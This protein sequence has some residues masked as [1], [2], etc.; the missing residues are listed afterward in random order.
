MKNKI[1]I[2]LSL[3]L[4]L[5]VAFSCVASADMDFHPFF[6]WNTPYSHLMRADGKD[7]SET[8][9][10]TQSSNPTQRWHASYTG[11]KDMSQSLILPS[12]EDFLS[13]PAGAKVTIRYRVLSNRD[14]IGLDSSSAEIQFVSREGSG[15]LFSIRQKL[16]FVSSAPTDGSKLYRDFELVIENTSTLTL[17]FNHVRIHCTSSAGYT[18]TLGIENLRYHVWTEAEKA[19][20]SQVD[21]INKQTETIT[22]GW[23]QSEVDPPPGA[24]KMEDYS[25]QE[26]ELLDGQQSGLE[27]GKQS[28]SQT[29]TDIYFYQG[30]FLGIASFFMS[31]VNAS[32]AMTFI[33][34]TSLSL[35]LC[36]FI[37]SLGM[38]IVRSA[39]DRVP[40]GRHGKGG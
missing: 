7:T 22:E 23:T 18:G 19:S 31:L 26:S 36:S 37:L 30:A 2:V 14:F 11:A 34:Y 13:F 9:T 28:F 15:N 6:L 12:Y 40:S 21:A 39:R 25:Q 20:A 33:V 38:M 27:S 1:L 3:L 24:D 29:L 5:S 35:G 17:Y 32:P 8:L 10:F 16:D 4:A